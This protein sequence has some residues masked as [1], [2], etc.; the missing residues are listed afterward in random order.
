MTAFPNPAYDGQ[1]YTLGLRSWTYILAQDAW[2]L[3]KNGP[4][5]PTGT[6]GVTGPAGVLLTNLTV[7]TFTGD[8][9]TD[10]FELSI[11]PV[12]AYN[13]IVNIDGLV[14]TAFVYFYEYPLRL[15]IYCHRFWVCCYSF[16]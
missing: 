10:T 11:T 4:T 9:V 7:D 5:G 1:L 8:G 15:L 13:M 2:I 3:N 12:S 16:L 6:P 14:Q